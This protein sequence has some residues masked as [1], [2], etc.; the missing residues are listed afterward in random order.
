MQLRLKQ[1]GLT[2][3]KGLTIK[4]D[5]DGQDT[6]I[7]GDNATGKSTLA[8][9][10]AWLLFDRD[11]TFGT[12]MEIKNLDA[13][14]QAIH[15]LTHEVYGLFD[16]DGEE[17]LLRKVYAETWKT[18]RGSSTKE[19]SGHETQYF[20]DGVPV[21]K[22]EY[23]AKVGEIATEEEF[24]LLTSPSYF[25]EKLPWP[26]RRQ[27]LIELCGDIDDN[28]VV[29]S[30][31]T[32]TDK[33]MLNL[34]GII[35]KNSIDDHRKIL[36][37]RRKETS[38][39]LGQIPVKI[40]E[41]TKYMPDVKGIDVVA[42]AG[43]A[44]D[45]GLEVE[46]LQRMKDHLEKQGG[47]AEKEAELVTA[48]AEL[49]RANDTFFQGITAKIRDAEG[50]DD[51]T[52]NE[53][54]VLDNDIADIERDIA[55]MQKD[56][57][58]ITA[59]IEQKATAWKA[60]HA[61]VF[62]PPTDETVCPHCGQEIPEE[63]RESALNQARASFEKEKRG[64]KGRIVMEADGLKASRTAAESCIAESVKG[65]AEQQEKRDALRK[66]HA[67]L[68]EQIEGLKKKRSFGMG[69]QNSAVLLKVEALKS[70]I[71][72]LK[73]KGPAAEIEKVV[74]EIAQAQA[75]LAEISA[76]IESVNQATKIKD[77]VAEL[78]KEQKELAAA[79]ETAEHELYLMDKF[80]RAKAAML[81]ETINSHFELARF[82]LFE[83]QING[84]I[85]QCCEVMVNGVPY[86][87][88]LNNGARIQ[89]G[90]DIIKT[91]SRHYGKTMMTII[92]NSESITSLPEMDGQVIR[93]I[94]S[95]PDKSL[96]I[97][98]ANNKLQE[99]A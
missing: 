84:G 18:K 65:G 35:G 68:L 27:L 48:Q 20:A 38:Q 43:K 49:T 4:V 6:D 23:L 64:N 50:R 82:R 11:S 74:G 81:N 13:D 76:R 73:S 60:E 36:A 10:I 41:I 30:L 97:E 44:K 55:D 16:V 71:E 51:T 59:K 96:R 70:E 9:S 62:E 3:F 61:R 78:E 39:Q 42:E 15:N 29:D 2:N 80:D 24:K 54:R 28:Q 47:V 53:L 14:G 98:T 92:D 91:L 32:V 19:F 22:K 93:L 95:E 75:K 90:L 25:A 85:S 66:E 45:A 7:F 58:D 72:E 87:G 89:A 33:E 37:G 46:R 86:T 69:D 77:R 94:V 99:A 21:Q 5:L 26:N 56:V 17:L 57:A 79:F 52:R 88:N 12:K 34:P 31:V 63:T 8:D 1:L 67:A 83:E 40:G